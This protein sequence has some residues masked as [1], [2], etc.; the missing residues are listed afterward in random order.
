MVILPVILF[1]IKECLVLIIPLRIIS[2]G[3]EREAARTVGTVLRRHSVPRYHFLEGSFH[4]EVQFSGAPV[5]IGG[6]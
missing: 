3:P 4:T 1:L 6:Y 2:L 5:K